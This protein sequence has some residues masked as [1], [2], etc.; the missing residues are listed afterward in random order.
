[1]QEQ[2]E[3]ERRA[4]WLCL[5]VATWRRERSDRAIEQMALFPFPPTLFKENKL[6]IKDYIGTY[7]SIVFRISL[8]LFLMSPHN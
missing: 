6:N 2:S 3:A 5:N 4:I 8:F 1:M 7:H